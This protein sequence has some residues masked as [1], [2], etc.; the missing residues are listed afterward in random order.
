MRHFGMAFH[1][2]SNMAFDC[3]NNVVVDANL[4]T[5]L[6][7][8]PVTKTLRVGISVVVLVW[9]LESFDIGLVSVLILVLGPHW[10]LSSGQ[11]GLLG[12]SGTIGLLIGMLPA[13]RLADLYGRKKVLLAY[14][15]VRRL[16]AAMCVRAELHLADRA[17]ADRRPRRG[18]DLPRAV[19]D[20]LRVGK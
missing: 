6:D 11:I 14:R 3:P 16:H 4:L 20:D 19:P 2:W 1:I 15:C 8:A 18:R 12:A 10:D 5:R 7:R 9:L 13:G 17:A